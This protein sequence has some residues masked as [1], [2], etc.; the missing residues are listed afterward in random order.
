MGYP[1]G[2]P[3]K[4]DKPILDAKPKENRFI[5]PMNYRY[6]TLYHIISPINHSYWSYRPINNGMFTI[7]QLVIRIPENHP[8]YHFFQLPSGY[9]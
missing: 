4:S 9:D 6:I 3:A 7:Y 1:M 8:Q 2:R 5:T